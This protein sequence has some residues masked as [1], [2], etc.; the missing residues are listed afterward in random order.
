MLD[1][2]DVLG[3]CDRDEL[4]AFLEDGLACRREH[5]VAADNQRNEEVLGQSCVNDLLSNKARLSRED[6]LGDSGVECP[7]FRVDA[8]RAAGHQPEGAVGGDLGGVEPASGLL[9]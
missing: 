5:L 8:D 9:D 1:L 2:L 4:V 6:K 7:E 3:V